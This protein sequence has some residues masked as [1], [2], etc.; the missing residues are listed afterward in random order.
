[1]CTGDDDSGGLARRGAANGAV[2]PGSV[3]EA[4]RVAGVVLDYLNSP[5][6]ELDGAACGQVLTAL[7]TLHAKFTAA[8][9]A[10]LRRFDA[11]D[12]H[13]ADGYGSSSAWLAAMTKLTP[14]DAK[15]TVRQMRQFGNHPHLA[16]ALAT[17]DLSQ[18]WGLEIA[19][20]TNKLPAELRG[21]TDKILVRAAAGGASRD[22]LAVIAAAAYEKWRS[23]HPDPDDDGG[24]DDRYLAVG[25][26][27]GGAGVI[28]GNLTPECAA[29]VQ[30][31]LEALGKRHG[32]EDQRSEAQRFHDALQLG[33][34]LLIRAKM[35]PDRAG[36][37]TRVEVHIPLSQLRQMPGASALEQAWLNTRLGQPGYLTGKD[38]EAAACDALTIPIVTGHADMTIID[39]IIDL[40]LAAY[41][42]NQHVPGDSDRDDRSDASASLRAM[43]PGARDALRYSIA[44]LAVDFLSG[45]N[46]LAGLL[47]T[48]LLTQPYNTPSLPLDVGYSDDIPAH[49]RRAVILRD[50]RCAWPRCG[51]SACYCDV[52]HIVHKEDGGKTSV[53]DCILLCQFH[54]DICIH[55]WGWR[56]I[57]HPDGTTSAYGPHGQILHSHSPPTLRAG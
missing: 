18:S 49:I 22:D 26:T 51:K 15:A 13:D 53:S 43:S 57:L 38:A 48:T 24:F 41:H 37:D 46:G 12:A 8:H 31:V 45:P 44:R 14:R 20:W 21:E 32:P 34:E 25:S 7:A 47:R 52:H 36:A 56:I 40:A 35:V 54:H 42:H 1:M 10:F 50:K 28:R 17:G 6:A 23:Q 30:A 5:A 55:R 4:L 9:A 16:G 39:Q 29:A 19:G 33:C 2:V 11:A 3:A 27:F